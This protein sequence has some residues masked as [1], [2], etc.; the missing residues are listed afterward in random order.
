MNR[1]ED[2]GALI[3][4]PAIWTGETTIVRRVIASAVDEV[5]R[6]GP[7]CVETDLVCPAGHS[8]EVAGRVDAPNLVN[9][10]VGGE[11]G[12]D[13]VEDLRFE[14]GLCNCRNNFVAFVWRF[15]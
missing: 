13:G 15:L 9:A 14:V 6:S 2:I 3:S 1:V 7:S 12:A 5:Q 4:L 10:R 11:D 8:R